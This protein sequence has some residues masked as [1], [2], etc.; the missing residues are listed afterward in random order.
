MPRLAFE[1]E[2]PVVAP[3]GDEER[4]AV[5]RAGAGRAGRPAVGARPQREHGPE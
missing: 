1:G 2:Q 5:R 4:A 3:V